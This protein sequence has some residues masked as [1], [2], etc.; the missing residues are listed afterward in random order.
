MTEMTKELLRKLCKE[1]SLYTT[2]SLNDKL[3]LHYK[4][5]NTI[6]NLEE[7]TGLKT[8]WLEGN[9]LTQISGLDHQPLLRSL[10]LHENLIERIEGLDQIHELDSLNL[11]KNYIKYIDNLSHLSK[12]TSLNLANNALTT[13]DSIKHLLL[14]PSLQTIDLQ[15]NRLDDTTIIDIFAQLPDLRV[16][17]LQGNP[18]VRKIKN[19]RKTIIAKC[20]MLK[21]LDDRPVFDDERRRTNAWAKV[22]DEG[23]SLDEAQEA[24][25]QEILLIRKEKDEYDER[26]FR[27]FEE[28]MKEGLAIRQQRELEKAQAEALA[29]NSYSVMPPPAPSVD[30]ETNPFTGEK[31]IN[32]PESEQLRIAREKKWGLNNENFDS[33]VNAL[34]LPE[35][36]KEKIPPSDSSIFDAANIVEAEV[37]S[38]DN[39]LLPPPPPPIV[40]KKEVPTM[41]ESDLLSLD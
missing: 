13:Y 18:V 6:K 34:P 29:N 12:L 5:F 8:L 22:L 39:A 35:P 40:I 3:Y 25:R 28:M 7:Y 2:P 17:Y 30:E 21:Y 32:V 19:Y 33:N 24:E 38:N 16:L 23:G 14:L 11:S 27:A 1:N 31:I 37:N 20:K 36:P 41:T 9:G 4:G 15:Q 26:N 10:Y